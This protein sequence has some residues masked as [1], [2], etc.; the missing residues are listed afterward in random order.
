VAASVG[1]GVSVGVVVDVGAGVA[2][3]TEVTVGLAV[4]V[5][6]ESGGSGSEN[7]QAIIASA[8][9]SRLSFI[10]RMSDIIPCVESG[11]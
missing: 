9:K 8:S 7:R 10:R 4:T 5:G 1:T 2:A 3:G 11:D 6:V